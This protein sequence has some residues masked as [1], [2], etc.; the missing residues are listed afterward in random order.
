M[1]DFGFAVVIT[2]LLIQILLDRRGFRKWMERIDAREK[3]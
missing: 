1:Q 3:K 2:L